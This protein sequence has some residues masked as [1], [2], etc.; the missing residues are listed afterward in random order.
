MVK[1][2][3]ETLEIAAL[4]DRRSL[5][6]GK[7][8]T[9]ALTANDASVRG[10]ALLAL[11]RIGD[12]TGFETLAKG[13]TDPDASARGEAAFGIGL[14]GL[15]WTPLPD[16]VK[17]RLTDALKTA[18]VEEQDPA[19]KLSLLE[20]LGRIGTPG[21]L[22]RLS[23]RLSVTGDVQA[24]AALSLGVAAKAG[25][26]L[27]ARTLGTL[28][29]LLKKEGSAAVRYGAAYALAQSKKDV[30]RSALLQC[31]TDDASE[32]RAICARGLGDVGVDADV[33]VLRKLLD[34][35]DYRVAAEATRTLAKLASK[36]RS[37]TCAAL[38]V[39]PEL[40]G[41]VERL[42]RGDTPGGGQPLLMLA[43]TGLP[44]AGRPVLQSLRQQLLANIASAPSGRVRQEIANIECRLAAALDKQTGAPAESLACGGTLI[45]EAQRLATALKE[46]AS[47][48][49][50]DAAKRVADIGAYSLHTDSRVKLAAIEALGE[51]RSILAA[52]KLRG[53]VTS[54]DPVIASAAAAALGKVGDRQSIPSIR[55]LASRA[56]AHVSSA[57]A[58][59]EALA[60]L[61]AKDAIADLEPW[62]SSPHPT[63]SAAAAAALTAL[64]RSP[65]IAQRVER[66]VEFAK[67]MSL[68]KE[69]HLLLRTEKGTV[70]IKL[71][72]EEAPLTALNIIGLARQG[73]FRNVTFHRIVPDFVAQGGDPRGDGEGGPDHTIRCEVNRRVYARGVVGMALSGKDTGG[74]QF[75]VTVAPQPHL[76]GRYTSFGE[77]VSGQEVV[78]ALL[79]GDAILEVR[80]TP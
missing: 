36:C 21:A 3:S 75:F 4:E 62:L 67:A 73:F 42:L 5:G 10:R 33:S 60:A 6:D 8:A 37:G 20:A 66:P 80:V 25:A 38:G 40:S 1:F 55:Q 77:V 49:V 70:D 16:E 45:S 69:A 22:E 17:T 44:L 72:T 76:D 24:K 50:V 63:V 7:L 71:F 61:D 30:A 64:K 79:E 47:A 53:H 9:L 57:P 35:P 58:I 15:S 23:E 11:G 34:D 26:V 48:P 68:A 31:S 18:E 78:D 74:S 54:A 28:I 27:P 65:V 43:Q 51:T 19:V 41:R 52:E 56:L 13:L 29:P 2:S 14:L 46:I 39:L 59:A 12:P 32:I